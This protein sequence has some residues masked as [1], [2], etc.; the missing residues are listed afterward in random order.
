M[1][2][3]YIAICTL[4]IGLVLLITTFI[5]VK[6]ANPVESKY[7]RKETCEL[8]SKLD[9][10]C[11]YWDKVNK[12]CRKGKSDGHSRCKSNQPVLSPILFF[13]AIIFLSISLFKFIQANEKN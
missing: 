5:L 2:P 6:I 3:I 11:L 1:K 4:V 8:G 7:T 12:K 10:K 13:L 9:N